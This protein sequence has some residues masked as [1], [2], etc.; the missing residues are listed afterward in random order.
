[1]AR[2]ETVLWKLAGFYF[3]LFAYLGVFLPWL[4]PLLRARGFSPWLIGLALATV[5]LSRSLLPPLWGLLADRLRHQR[6]LLATAAMLAGASLMGLALPGGRDAIFVWLFLHGLFLVPLFPL[7]EVI[8]LRTLGPRCERYGQVRLWG[9]VGF[10]VTTVGLGF[11]SELF[12]RSGEAGPWAMGLPLVLAGGL[13]LTMPVARSLRRQ[14]PVPISALPASRRLPGALFLLIVA[15][16]LGQGSHGPYYAFFTIQLE[17]AGVGHGLI[18]LLWGWG[19]AAEV[20]L[21]A[22]SHRL[23]A[24][25]GLRAAFRGALAL[26][27]A[28]WFLYASQPGLVVLAL[29]QTLHAASFA[30]LHVTTIQLADRLT[31]TRCKVLGQSLV[32][33]GAYGFGIGAGSFLAGRFAATLSYAGLYAAAAVTCLVALVVSLFLRDHS[34]H[35]GPMPRAS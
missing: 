27:C 1:M 26:G 2:N 19:V 20:L 13:A 22:V 23:I 33:A 18:S 29:G 7:A 35:Q 8:T 15:A 17:D 30:L 31:P 12:G 11:G 14:P 21:M 9:S 3:L 5:Q 25:W 32:S 10:I 34:M 4:P 28:R 6:R 24:R 16:G